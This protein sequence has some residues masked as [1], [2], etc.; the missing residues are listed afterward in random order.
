[1]DIEKFCRE[2][3]VERRGTGT[4][5]WD[6][7]QEIFGDADLLPL[8]VADMEIQ[9]PAAVRE[10]LVKRVEHGVFGYGTVEDTCFESFF[11]WQ[12]KHHNVELAR[13]NIRFATGVVGSLYAAV[14]AYTKEE[15]S[16]IICPPVYYP[17]YDA[18]LNTGRK[19]VTCELDNN[20]GYYTLDFERFEKE[21]VDNK[22][23]M[24]ILCSPHNP[25]SRVWS[26][27]E[28]DTMFGICRRHG[29]LVVSDEIHQDF[30]YEGK[31]FVSSALVMNG[32]YKDILITLNAGSKTFNLAGLIHSHVII[33]DKPLMETYDAYIKGIGSPE[34]NLMGVAGVEAAF[35]GGE[36]WLENVKAL[37]IHNYNYMKQEFA[38]E[39]PKIVVT[40]LEGTYLS[41]I[42]LRG[43]LTGEETAGFIQN[44]CRLACDAGEWFS[45]MAHG[46][47]RINLATD[48]KNVV[49][50]V[51][52]IIKNIKEKVGE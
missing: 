15:A 10:A 43:Y 46:F 49:T 47:I 29:V 22:V 14:R 30:T 32:K 50:A 17:F 16:V 21:I 18:I 48:T 5:K 24:F 34:V 12:K 3:C 23:E 27:E 19:L 35:R 33:F 52:S 2:N 45:L 9:S 37:I 8:W 40:P 36:E 20:N 13:E 1:M 51:E 31:K 25:V 28:L 6:S 39:L 26:E 44:K 7:L 38:R 41:W 11:A 4:L 42:D